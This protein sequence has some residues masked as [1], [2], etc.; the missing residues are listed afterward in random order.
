[1]KTKNC[2]FKKKF[3]TLQSIKFEYSSLI[4]LLSETLLYLSSLTP[5][6]ISQM[7]NYELHQF[8]VENKIKEHLQTLKTFQ[9]LDPNRGNK[10]E[11]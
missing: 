7:K 3:Q 5:K 2:D 4:S 8:R 9:M 6:K 10:E 1:M 11:N